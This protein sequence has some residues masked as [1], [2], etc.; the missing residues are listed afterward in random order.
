MITV[1]A[2]LIEKEGKYLIARRSTGSED[3]MGKWEFPG[4]KVENDESEEHA[5]EREIKEEFDVCYFGWVEYNEDGT[6]FSQ[7]SK[8]YHF[9]D[10]FISGEEAAKRKYS[11]WLW[12]CNCNE[13]YSLKMIKK[14]S[15]K[16]PVG[17][18]S[19]EDT[20]FIY[21]CLAHA[22]KVCSLPKD[23]FYNYIHNTSLMHSKFNERFVTLFASIKELYE[24]SL[25][26]FNE[27]LINIFYSLY[28]FSGVTIAK[29]ISDS[30]KWYNGIK[31]SKECKKYIPKMPKERKLVLS[32][33]DKMQL[34]IYNFSKPLFLL[35]YKI[36]K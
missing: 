30:Y 12:L 19:G 26:N 4:G 36:F 34:S 25:N 32:K 9:L 3:V 15:I 18:Y 20:C 8:T 33:K 22:E 2:A 13:I 31:F 28:H 21:K 14:Y 29:K 16:Y 10:S 5:I 24:Y 27:D 23:Y 35:V 17:V 11:G 1:V 6:V 7:F